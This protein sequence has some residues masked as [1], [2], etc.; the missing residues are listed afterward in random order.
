ME[1]CMEAVKGRV[2]FWVK[3]NVLSLG[4]GEETKPWL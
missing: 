3:I 4:E 2:E 1:P